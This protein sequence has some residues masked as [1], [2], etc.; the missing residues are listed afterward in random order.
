MTIKYHF[1]C[2]LNWR[3]Q[4]IVRSCAGPAPFISSPAL[5][6]ATWGEAFFVGSDDARQGP[7]DKDRHLSSCCN[8][9]FENHILDTGAALP[10]SRGTT[11]PRTGRIA[12]KRPF[13]Q[14]SPSPPPPKIDEYRIS[15]LAHGNGVQR[16][17][18]SHKD[19]D[20]IATSF[21]SCKKI[22]VVGRSSK[23]KKAIGNALRPN[24]GLFGSE[25]NDFVRTVLTPAA[26]PNPD[27]TGRAAESRLDPNGSIWV[28][29]A[30]IIAVLSC[31]L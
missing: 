12:N 11:P 30:T 15:V 9:T 1:V 7:A 29:E 10:P 16:I 22:S 23:R 6:L 28:N 2:A 21:R 13:L 20:H 19:N 17:C 4:A 3:P 18:P 8:S 5:L 14:Q 24:G 25:D 26:F 31:I 27:E